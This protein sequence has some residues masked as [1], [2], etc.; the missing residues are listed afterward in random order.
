LQSCFFGLL[1]GKAA[2]QEKSF[3]WQTARPRVW[4]QTCQQSGAKPKTGV[5]EG[6]TIPPSRID[7]HLS[8]YPMTK[9]A[10]FQP[11]TW[12]EDIPVHF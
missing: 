12:L 6:E 9:D 10:Q 5:I 3:R 11:V 7:V 8:R 2:A 4:Y 1:S